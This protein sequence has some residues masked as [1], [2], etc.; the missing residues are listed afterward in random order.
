MSSERI[1]LNWTRHWLATGSALAALIG[2]MA[3]QRMI[4]MP[5]VSNALTLAVLGVLIGLAVWLNWPSRPRD[6][7]DLRVDAR[8]A[9]IAGYITIGV[10]LIQNVVI[11]LGVTDTTPLSVFALPGLFML[12]RAKIAMNIRRHL[13]NGTDSRLIQRL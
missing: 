6:E 2:G 11:A 13:I 3:A 9:S 8:G 10:A 4:E 5:G 1:E 7:F 12:C